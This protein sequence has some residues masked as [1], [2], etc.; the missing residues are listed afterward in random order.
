MSAIIAARARAVAVPAGLWLTAIVVC[1]I[2][3][4]VA[5]GHRMVAPWIMVDE[6][7]YSELAKNVAAHGEFLVRGVPSHG[8]GFVYP[9]LISPAWKLF[10]SIPD[11]YA[12]AKAIDAVLM[13]LAAIPAYFLAR[14]VL[15]AGL[16]LVSAVLAVLIPSM[17]Y[18]GMLMTE[19]AFYPLFLLAAFLLVLTLEAP[20]AFRQIA[21]LAVCGIA[22]ETR[23]QAVALF[24][25]V[26]TAP[27][28]LALI[29]RR[30]ARATLRRYGWLY[31]LL[32]GGAAIALAGT[33]AAGRSPLSLLGAYRAATSSS[34]TVSGVLHF[35]L[36]H[37]AELDLYLGIFPF[38]ALLALWLAPRRPSPG[39]RAF[40]AASLAIWVWLLAEVAA[41]ASA[42]F[43]NRIGAEHVL[44]GATRSDR[45]RR[46]GRRRCR[47]SSSP[48]ARRGR[49]RRGDPPVLHP[50][51]ALHQ[52]E[53][54][55]GHLCADAVV[56]G[57]GQPDPPRPGALGS[58]H[59]LARRGRVLHLGAAAE[60]ARPARARRRLVHR[61]G[62][63]RRERPPWDPQDHRRLALGGD[64]H[65]PP[66][67][68]RSGGWAECR[69]R[70]PLDGLDAVRLP[71][72]RE[73]VLQPERAHR[74]RRR[75]RRT[76]RSAPRDGRDAPLRRQ[77]RHRGREG[78]QRPV[79]PRLD[80]G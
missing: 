6:L 24:A 12:A 43:V 46:D 10:T 31:G 34:Y 53:R 70:R 7:V 38:A 15:P 32:G 80:R 41:F 42:S 3:V 49:D 79:R 23:A 62:L 16:S 11:A 21:L 37:V 5:L 51:R 47:H 74:L 76:P 27:V 67:L 19:N 45:A 63:R 77:A 4:R 60:G 30:G 26:A 52:H 69:R 58:A 29:E 39:A 18:T 2:V 33:V 73:R 55:V 25:A 50:V 1:S 17:L 22:F 64:A 66:E 28:L 35:F 59:R 9:I 14:R 56:V 57:A 61:D 78:H 54:G 8:Y 40:A 13:S 36:Y 75:R 71:G 68:D 20:T 72:L 48:G 65:A 44:P